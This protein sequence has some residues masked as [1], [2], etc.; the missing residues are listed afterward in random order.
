MFLVPLSNEQKF[1][2]QRF[3][4]TFNLPP[5]ENCQFSAIAI[6]NRLNKESENGR[7]KSVVCCVS[8]FDLN[9]NWTECAECLNWV[10]CL[11]EGNFSQ[12]T[13]LS[14][15][16]H[17]QSFAVFFSRIFRKNSVQVSMYC[18]LL[19]PEK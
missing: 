19:K 4:T 10:N 9:I 14:D 2:R 15:D 12:G 3:H 16:A 7:C 1:I 17:F 6:A 8:K 5:N 11:Y 18:P 13:S